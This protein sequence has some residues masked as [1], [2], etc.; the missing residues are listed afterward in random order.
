MRKGI[1]EPGPWRSPREWAGYLAALSEVGLPR[2]FPFEVANFRLPDDIS[3]DAD[4]VLFQAWCQG[5]KKSNF[6]KANPLVD[7]YAASIRSGLKKFA[8]SP[9]VRFALAAPHMQPIGVLFPGASYVDSSTRLSFLLENP[10]HAT[11]AELELIFASAVYKAAYRQARDVR[12]LHDY[13][14]PDGGWYVGG[15]LSR[16]L[17]P[18]FK[19]GGIQPPRLSE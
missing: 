12:R 1:R 18:H 7:D 6:S 4:V 11:D 8:R 2:V 15:R 13:L 16:A 14:N 10:F 9:W 5:W 3:C 17:G 19:R